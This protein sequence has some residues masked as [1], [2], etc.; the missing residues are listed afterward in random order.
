MLNWKR[1]ISSKK[2]DCH[3]HATLQQRLNAVFRLR[4]QHS[5][6]TLCR[7]LSVHRSTYYK[8]FSSCA[9]PRIVQNQ[10]ISSAI[11]RICTEYKNSI[12]AY[13]IQRVLARDYGFAM[14]VGRVYRLMAKMNL[15]KMSTDKSKF[16]K[17]PKDDTPGENFLAQAFYPEAPNMVWASDFTYIKVNGS[18][19]YLCI[20]MDL[21]APKIVGWSVSSTHSVELTKAALQKA[22]AARGG[23]KNLLFHS[24]QGSEYRAREFQQLLDAYS[25]LSSFSK[26]GYPYDNACCESFFNQMKRECLLRTKFRSMK[27][28][29]L[30]CFEYI[31]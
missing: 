18:F 24:D 19:L 6:K 10:Q 7:V 12:G 23:A 5:I 16:K 2:S 1:R 30:A 26:K 29:Q 3:L 15:P 4:S 27:E 17:A 22:H 25:F 21:F 14:S 11:L 13:K 8:H 9:A 20:V 28:L 31:E